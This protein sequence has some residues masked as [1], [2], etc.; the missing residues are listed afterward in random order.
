MTTTRERLA[1]ALEGDT[2]D[3]TP[4]SMYSWMMDRPTT[5][6]CTDAWRRLIDA[7]LGL[8][9]HCQ[10]VELLEH[11][12]TRSEETRTEGGDRYLIRTIETPVGTLRNVKHN[13]WHHEDW[14]KSPEDYAI[15]QWI[16][17]HTEV[18]PRYENFQKA[19]DE[20]GDDGVVVVV[21]G[22]RTPAM[23]INI[24]WAGTERFC[25]DI[26]LE[27]PELLSLYEAQCKL[28]RQVVEAVAAGP[29]RFVK[30]FEN[31]TIDM[32]GPRRYDDL[33]VSVYDECVPILEG[34]DKRVM[35]HYDGEL[36]VIA[37]NIARAPFHIVESLSEPPEGDMT[38]DQCRRHW[39][40]KTF[41]ANINVGLYYQPADVLKQEVI[42]KRE[43][44][45]KCALAF[46]I[47]EDLPS[48]WQESIPVVL[49]T[50]RELG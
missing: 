26:A 45:G 31:L 35:V 36:S 29:G 42:A 5:R 39:P 18:V 2:P 3:L 20:V 15:R 25:M 46:E 47:S 48:N 24:D 40:D 4:L 6:D 22:G 12:V 28:H 27:V 34:G 44:A 43:R 23:D 11:G 37:D 49:D 13:G 9:H 38:Y 30:W 21:A 41:W 33:L 1:T 7:G 10:T 32:L 8:A 17:E 50:L 19:S 16:V 14:I